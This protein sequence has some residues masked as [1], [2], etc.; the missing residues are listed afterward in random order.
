MN[1]VC[2]NCLKP[3][4][5]ED[6]QKCTRGYFCIDCINKMIDDYLVGEDD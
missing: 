2:E 3:V 5:E 1:F 4:D 6:L